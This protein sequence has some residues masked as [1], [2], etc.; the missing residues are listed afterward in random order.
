MLTQKNSK[1]YDRYLVLV[2]NL[3]QIDYLNGFLAGLFSFLIALRVFKES[4]KLLF[5]NLIPLGG[6]GL[7]FAAYWSIVSKI[8]FKDLLTSNLVS[9]HFG[10]PNQ[11]DFSI[12]PVGDLLNVTLMKIISSENHFS[13]AQALIHTVSILKAFPI[14]MVAYFCFRIITKLRG[15]SV[16]AAVFFATSSYNLIR[17]EGHFLLG[18]TWIVPVCLLFVFYYYQSFKETLSCKSFLKFF[19]F[20][21]II[22]LSGF[23]Y[24]VFTL[25]LVSMMSVFLCVEELRTNILN[26]NTYNL[27][28]GSF[29]YLKSILGLLLGLAIQIMPVLIAQSKYLKLTSTAD[30]SPTEAYIFSGNLESLF[31]EPINLFLTRINR[32]D[33]VNYLNSQI[34][35]EASQIGIL[36]SL[37]LLGLLLYIIL[38]FLFKLFT[39]QSSA[40]PAQIIN[41]LSKQNEKFLVI[42]IVFCLVLYI[43]SPLNFLISLIFPQIRAWGRIEIFLTFLLLALMVISIN[44][45][46]Q[47][48][49]RSI[50]IVI[51]VLIQ[52]AYLQNFMSYRQPSSILNSIANSQNSEINKSIAWLNNKYEAKCGLVQLPIYP[53]PEFDR[54]DDSNG[55][56]ELF[57][58]PL[59]SNNFQWSY[60]AF[61]STENFKYFQNLISEYPN[62]TRAP[63]VTQIK[64]AINLGAC[65]AIIDKTYLTNSENSEFI[66]LY[67]TEKKC[68]T[69]IPGIKIGNENRFFLIDFTNVRCKRNLVQR[70]GLGIF[71][72]KYNENFIYRI[73]TPYSKYIYNGIEFFQ[74]SQTIAFRVIS[75][76]DIFLK[77]VIMLS[78]KDK[79][80]RSSEV[81][82][83]ASYLNNEKCQKSSIN[84]QNEFEINL[85][86]IRRHQLSKFTLR[87]VQ[88]EPNEILNWGIRILEKKQN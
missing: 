73:D 47:K 54:P 11:I 60:G 80:I 56:Y 44:G 88:K 71:K 49:L 51:V 53:F 59:K 9:S 67:L 23:Y 6:D 78:Y 17:A 42:S 83:C 33:L 82:V 72:T 70:N 77:S 31:V 16:L 5:F 24:A 4:A 68:V 35:W 21:L 69:S 81:E 50:A 76:N 79:K 22:G 64:S 40:N 20:G 32:I 52:F 45:I 57:L 46:K 13:N 15:L 1:F 74:S 26:S 62:F 61:K 75:N 66:Q 37:F 87:I 41:Q 19:F 36:P 3:V 8:G 58:L 25:L 29:Y 39:T 28:R 27:A 34:N 84:E 18:I 14:G 30:R 10:W 38:K 85:G 86:N 12:Y 55:D 65:A 2:R 63:L 7:F 43:R 48:F